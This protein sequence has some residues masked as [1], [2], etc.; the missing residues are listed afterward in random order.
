[1]GEY[2]GQLLVLINKPGVNGVI[3]VVEV[4]RAKP[5]D[6]TFGWANLPILI[7]HNQQKNY[8]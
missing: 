1:M 2:L 6:Y 4:A 3:A 8:Q 5:D 7:I